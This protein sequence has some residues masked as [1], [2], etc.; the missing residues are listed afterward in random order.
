MSPVRADIEEVST[1]D[2]F[3]TEIWKSLLFWAPFE[4]DNVALD[5]DGDGCPSTLC[6]A[7]PVSEPVTTDNRGSW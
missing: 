2:V 5:I 4:P 1:V 6:S 7:M 3:G